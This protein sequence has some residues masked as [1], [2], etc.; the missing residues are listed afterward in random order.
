MKSVIKRLTILI[1]FLAILFGVTCR[2]GS[3]FGHKFKGDTPA[4]EE[5]T[6]IATFGPFNLEEVQKLFPEAASLK[7]FKDNGAKVF[8]SN[9]SLLGTI[10]HSNP[11]CEQITGFAASVPMLI[12]IGSD[13]KIIGV[14]LLENK[15][16]PGFLKRVVD[17]GILNKWNGVAL[18]DAISQQVDAVTGATMS[19]SAI[20]K[21]FQTRLGNHLQ[22]A[23]EEKVKE[24]TASK[25]K[26]IA[27]LCTWFFLIMS[28]WAYFPKTRIGKYR[29]I[30]LAWSVIMPGFLFARFISLGLIKAWATDGI[31]FTTQIF[32]VVLMFLAI[33]LPLITGRAYYCVWYCPFG[34]A[35][36]L[37]GALLKNKY[38]PKGKLGAYLR[39]TRP[40]I[41]IILVASLLLGYNIDLYEFEPFTA[42][43]LS[44]VSSFV[45]GLAI[46]FL[47]LA[48]FIRRPWCNYCCPT[49][50]ILESIRYK[51]VPRTVHSS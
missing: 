21:T 42:F 9:G 18:H 49:G 5:Q 12:A 10:L 24:E 35:Q 11:D 7:L 25:Y 45:L 30:M 22:V 2:S 23:L 48:L 3:F 8:S 38:T 37:V 4:K 32:M 20:I 13:D 17:T 29:K 14:T 33:L 51:A 34:A 16:T 26:T 44:S 15:E 27:E 1:V 39:Y 50:M 36:E 47:I 43:V 40:A 19:S 46:T 31:P 41:L 28:V 6:K